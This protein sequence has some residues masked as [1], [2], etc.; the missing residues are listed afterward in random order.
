METPAE[1]RQVQG[2]GAS[3]FLAVVSHRG[4]FSPAYSDVALDDDGDAASQ[5]APMST[6]LEIGTPV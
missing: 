4:P 2:Y 6:K 3:G 5:T 1:E